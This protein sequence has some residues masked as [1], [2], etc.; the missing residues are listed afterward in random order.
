MKLQPPSMLQ[1]PSKLYGRD[2]DI[3]TL[4]VSFQQVCVGSGKIQL[5]AGHSGVGKTVLVREMRESVGYSNGFFLE[6]KFNQYQQDIPYFAIRQALAGLCIELGQD[7]VL[8]RQRWKTQLL[9]AV[10]NQGQLLVDLVPELEAL[11][12]KQ[13]P[14]A[15]ISPLEARCRFETVFREF[16]KVLCRPEHPVV[17]FI[18]D[19]QWADAASIDLL[20]KLQVDSSLRYLMVIV[21]YRDNEVDAAHPLI[22]AIAELKSLNVPLDV[23]EV[24]TLTQL[25]VQALLTDVLQPALDDLLELAALVFRRTAGN[26]FFTKTLI[27]YLYDQGLIQFEAKQSRWIWHSRDIVEAELP[28]DLIELFA[29][30]LQQLAAGHRKLLAFAACLGHRFDLATL[31]II[32][33]WSVEQCRQYLTAPVTQGLLMPVHGVLPESWLFLHDRVQQAAYGFIHPAELPAVRLDI[34]RRLLTHLSREQLSERIF[35]VVDHLNTGYQLIQNAEEQIQVLSLNVE[36]ARKAYTATAYRTALQFLRAAARF[37]ERPGFSERLWANHHSL[38]M[39]LYLAQADAEFLEG[40][41]SESENCVHQAVAHA[42]NNIEKA[43]ALNVLIVHFTL[44]A[45]YPEAIAAGREALA[46]LGIMLPEQDFNTFRDIEIEQLRQA[47]NTSSVADLFQLPVMTDPEICTAT[48]LLITMGPPCYR[49]HQRLW[50]VIVPKVVNLTIRYGNIPQ[51]G[52]SHTAFGGLLGWVANDYATAKAFGELATRLMT[53]TFDSLSYQSVFYLMSGSSLRHWFEHLKF[54]SRDYAL[55]YET[56]SR[57]GNLQYAAYAFGHNMYCQFYQGTPLPELIQESQRSLEFSQ[58]RVNQWA[59]DLLMGGLKL[60]DFLADTSSQDIDGEWEQDYLREVDDHYNI[61]VKCIYLELKAFSCLILG[62]FT[63]A[64]ALSDQVEPLIY[65][66][67]TQGL[68]PWPEHVFS[69]ALI[70][71][72]L[73]SD[74]PLEQ[75]ETWLVALNNTREQLAI[76]ASWCPDNFAHKHAFIT[77][78]IAR[79]NGQRLEALKFYHQAATSAAAGGFLQWAGLA[80][81]RAAI[82]FE[83]CGQ[84]RLAN[85]YWQQAYS[86]FYRWGASRKLQALETAYRN[87]L[88]KDLQTSLELGVDTAIDDPTLHTEL[89]VKQLQ[90]LRRPLEELAYVNLQRESLYQSEEL[91]AATERLRVEVAERK[92]AEHQLQ[93]HHEQLEELVQQRTAALEISRDQLIEAH[94]KTQQLMEEAII[95]RNQSEDARIALENE[96]AERKKLMDALVMSEQEFH[97]LAEAMPQIVWI[98]RADGWNIYFNQQWVDYTGLTLAES[99]GHGWNKPFHPDDQQGAWDTWQNAVNNNGT[100]S[101]ECRIR[102]ADGVYRWWLVRGIPVLDENGK[103]YKWFGTCTD[104]EDLTAVQSLKESEQRFRSLVTATSQIVWLADTNGKVIGELPEWHKFTGQDTESTKHS[105]WLEAIHPDDRDSTASI[106]A[107]AVAEH[108]LFETECR[109]RRHDGEYRDFSVRGVPIYTADGMV[110]EWVGTCTD[111]T[112]SK[113]AECVIQDS[114]HRLALATMASQIGIWDWYLPSNT[115]IWDK[116]ML[117]LYGECAEECDGLLAY[118][119]WRSRVHPDDIEFAERKLQAAIEGTGTYD[120]VFRIIMPDGAIHFIE[121]AGYVERDKSGQAIRLVG[122]NRDITAQYEAALLLK[123]QKDHLATLFAAN[124]NG[125]V[126]VDGEGY[127]QM[128]NAS[129]LQMFGYTSEELL[130]QSIDKLV[131]ENFRDLHRRERQRFMLDPHTRPMGAENKDL[132]G[133]HRDGSTFPVEISLASFVLEGNFQVQA[134]IVDISDRRLREQELEQYRTQLETMVSDRT[135]ELTVRTV[136]L[137]NTSRELE[138]M[139]RELEELYNQAP[140]GYHSLAKDA[141]ILRIN[142]TELNWLGYPRDEVV[143]KKRITD[144]MTDASVET[145]KVIFPRLLAEGRIQDLALEFVRKDGSLLVGLLSE[146]VGY[147]AQG[148]VQT[149]SVIQD[150]TKLRNQ[151]ETLRNTLSASPMAVYIT[152]LTDQRIIFLNKAFAQLVQRNADEVIG[153]DIRLNYA[154]PAV[155]DDIRQQLARGEIILNRLVELHFPDR[156]EIPPA[157]VLCSFMVFD[158]EGEQAVLGW[159]YDV[160]ELQLAKSMAEKSNAAKSVFLA[161]MSHEIRTPLNAIIGMSYLLEQTKLTKEQQE[162]VATIL[163]SS[164]TLL[165]LINDVLDISKIEANEFRLDSYQFSLPSLIEE[166]RLIGEGLA[167]AKDLKL[168]IAPLPVGLPATFSG[169]AARL[170][171]ML[172]NLLGNAIKFTDQGSAGLDIIELK[173]DAAAHSTRLRFSI[174]DTGV[175]IAKESYGALFK[176]FSQGKEVINRRVGGTGLGLSLVKQLAE[177]MGGVV[178]FES[179]LGHG[180]TFWIEI[181][182]EFSDQVLKSTEVSGQHSLWLDGVHV[183]VVDDSRLN[184]EVCERLLK[185]EGARVTLCESG[186]EAIEI[187]KRNDGGPYDLILMDIQMPG[188]DGCETTRIIK[189]EL[190]YTKLPVVALTAG[191]LSEERERALGAGMDDFL[192]KPIDPSWLVRVLRAHIENARKISVPLAVPGVAESS[193]ADKEWPVIDEIDTD[194]AFQVMGG[195]L[196][197]YIEILRLFVREQGDPATHLDALLKQ[198]KPEEAA[199]WVHKLRGQAGNIGAVRLF[200]VAGALEEAI[201]QQ[202][203]DIQYHLDTLVRVYR[204][205]VIAITS[206]MGS[207]PGTIA[208]MNMMDCKN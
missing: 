153:M 78:E 191:A 135:V 14:I 168:V 37:L 124:P 103:I 75:Q 133:L 44:L 170:K 155:F 198:K 73:Y 43:E 186:E 36:A 81:E 9:Q 119:F 177:M 100:Y 55:A 101:L 7:D 39:Q 61:Q 107:K 187:L 165:G 21:S 110:S 195:N 158:Y 128:A 163:T 16:F 47:L 24:H 56:G 193:L 192:T 207:Q 174:T 121:G 5:V 183:L 178:G 182:F 83:A 162:E 160:T 42:A 89:L 169:D 149:R 154:D 65:T 62:Q 161:S 94:A 112:D 11:I 10:G 172:M 86:C 200:K 22:A 33:D 19:W 137:E 156:P 23:L 32:G 166:L 85:L 38:A 93:L 180:S 28:A 152:R 205:L 40:N 70:I 12:G 25:E 147:D 69:R 108:C 74:A 63:D 13:P 118:D 194:Q 48:K 34:G 126:V 120:T 1:F 106:W 179:E 68:L 20:T 111:I 202:T 87:F 143:G 15:E 150:F 88:T 95:A 2:Q 82:L 102:R 57:S 90:Q 59:I 6:G 130:G 132:C 31:V 197:L 3:Q 138:I 71:S 134:T 8:Q 41:R 58:T 185:E 26:P 188:M 136:E 145:F 113:Y 127:I 181:P 184:L 204:S 99:Y 66:V 97:Q 72:A 49:S 98:T 51:I 64:L 50:S 144:F 114:Q 45:R 115:L 208:S 148:N 77:G 116:R 190:K 4:L 189:S 173:H 84:G 27:E 17:L 164:K 171:Q 122:T 54:G 139:V 46:V 125:L 175:G 140:C 201:N 196:D 92:H 60:F 91:V 157:W 29:R 141:T 80:N 176:P 52:Y 53:S 79:L 206:W 199:N 67:G 30:K 105:G 151:Q 109:I 18:D 159:M 35:Q 96:V 129:L 76:W 167:A 146:T 104:I 131:P 123:S 117:S 203:P 142:D